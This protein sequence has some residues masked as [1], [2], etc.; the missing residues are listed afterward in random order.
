MSNKSIHDLM[1]LSAL[2]SLAFQES[3]TMKS[4]REMTQVSQ[5]ATASF[6]ES[7]SMKAMRNMVKTSQLATFAFEESASMKAVREMAQASQ[8]VF[9]ESASMRVMREMMQGSQLASLAF[10]ES[11]A[12][13]AVREIIDSQSL[14]DLA[15]LSSLK[16]AFQLENSPFPS[17]TLPTYGVATANSESVNEE[18]LEIDSELNDEVSSATDFNQLSEK[19]K[20][21]LSYIFHIYILPMLFLALGV[22]ISAL[23]GDELRMALESVSTSSEVRSFT[24]NAKIKFDRV[25]LASFRVTT[26]NSLK[27]RKSPNMSAETID[28]L[29]LGTLVEVIERSN[30]SWLFVE[31]EMD[32]EFIQGWVSR[33]YT[34]YFK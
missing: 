7:A 18:I 16:A 22:C 28:F 19:S 33:K 10:Q 25:A 17:S 23:Y 8:L 11:A 6:Q 24:R 14:A 13:K 21:I 9:Q 3:A 32:G 27:L 20:R 2:S 34:V 29:P 26:A 15:G 5:L 4:I 31:V 1:K 12:M 30:R